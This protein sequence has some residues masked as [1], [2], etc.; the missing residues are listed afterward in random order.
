V[1]LSPDPADL[2]ATVIPDA[3]DGRNGVAWS[4]ALRAGAG[5]RG[6]MDPTPLLG[7]GL[8]AGPVRLEVEAGLP[9]TVVEDGTLQRG[10]ASLGAGWAGPWSLAPEV[11]AGVGA[12]VLWLRD[13]DIP[14]QAGATPFG[15]A[16][17]GL[18]L[19]PAATW[20]IRV[21]L[22]G[23]ADLRALVVEP[24]EGDVVELG[25]GWLQPGGSIL[26]R[27]R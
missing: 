27:F 4:L 18:R 9:G 1:A 8:G 12:A 10:A 13:P 21:S 23:G 19:Q 24:V 26:A 14:T 22:R 16:E 25:R 6:G 11:A 5:L 7:V 2:P 20:A 17:V 15:W 3:P